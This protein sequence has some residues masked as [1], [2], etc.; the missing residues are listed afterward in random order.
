M[1]LL[2]ASAQRLVPDLPTM[3]VR[4]AAALALALCAATL[5]HAPQPA[6]AAGRLTG[7]RGNNS[8]RRD[9]HSAAPASPFSRCF[10]RDE[11]R[12]AAK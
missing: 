1:A 6:A 12:G 10:R 4:G 8:R 3:V 11:E 5:L 7:F 9:R 2:A